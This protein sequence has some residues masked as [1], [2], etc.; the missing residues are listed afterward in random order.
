VIKCPL[1][2][3]VGDTVLTGTRKNPHG[4]IIVMT[5]VSGKA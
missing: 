1:D 4:V 3:L 5:Y 2:I